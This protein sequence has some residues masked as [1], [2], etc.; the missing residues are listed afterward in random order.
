M[1]RDQ[2]VFWRACAY[3]GSV[4]GPGSPAPEVSE[5]LG[6]AALGPNLSTGDSFNERIVSHV[7]RVIAAQIESSPMSNLNPVTALKPF[8]TVAIE[9]RNE[10]DCESADAWS[11]VARLD[12]ICDGRAAHAG[13]WVEGAAE[14][15]LPTVQIQD[16]DTVW[17]AFVRLLGQQGDEHTND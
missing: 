15:L 17:T 12:L 1:N 5:V 9:T 8:M 7:Y 14:R 3:Q 16:E 2:V 6:T 13:I 4:L 10:T 11:Q